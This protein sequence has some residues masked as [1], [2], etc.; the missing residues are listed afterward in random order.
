MA[1]LSNIWYA[2]TNNGNIAS[3]LRGIVIA[4]NPD[5]NGEIYDRLRAVEPK[6][7]NCL[8]LHTHQPVCL[9]TTQRTYWPDCCPFVCPNKGSG[10]GVRRRNGVLCWWRSADHGKRSAS[11]ARTVQDTSRCTSISLLPSYLACYTSCGITCFHRNP[12]PFHGRPG[13]LQH[14]TC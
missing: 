12:V 1:R 10:N 7:C 4:N 8:P 9:Q 5:G 14:Q 2:A 3:M 6:Q 13:R 11:T